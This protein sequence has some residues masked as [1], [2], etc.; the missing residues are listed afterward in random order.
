MACGCTC[1]NSYFIVSDSLKRSILNTQLLLQYNNQT[2]SCAFSDYIAL[3]H[4][5]QCGEAESLR[6]GVI[7][8]VKSLGI[9]TYT[10]CFNYLTTPTCWQF[11]FY[12]VIYQ[13]LKTCVCVSVSIIKTG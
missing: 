1:K 13:N 9:D 6:G 3:S 8:N 2:N 10:V 12:I 5:N 11:K 4:A 7:L